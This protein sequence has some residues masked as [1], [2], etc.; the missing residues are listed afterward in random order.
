MIIIRQPTMVTERIIP[1]IR[2]PRIIIMMITIMMTITTKILITT[3]IIAI[4][5]ITKVVMMEVV[6]VAVGF[7]RVVPALIPATI[8]RQTTM[9]K[10]A[11]R[12]KAS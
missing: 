4:P 10:V 2:K 7:R 1:I 6:V 11:V 12:S 3:G 5:T 8:L 9:K